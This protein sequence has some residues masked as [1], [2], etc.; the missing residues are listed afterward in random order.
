M[1]S[2]KL[3]TVFCSWLCLMGQSTILPVNASDSNLG[4]D[5]GL[6]IDEANEAFEEMQDE[7]KSQKDNYGNITIWDG[8]E[9]YDSYQQGI[10]NAVEALNVEG[11]LDR[12]S[13]V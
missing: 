2:V 10:R 1:N 9:I 8:D 12:K 4:D 6:N 3:L 11:K 7:F 5:T 13:V